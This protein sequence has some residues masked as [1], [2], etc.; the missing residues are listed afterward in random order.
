M[1]ARE[2][3]SGERGARCIIHAGKTADCE[4]TL[5]SGSRPPRSPIFWALLVSMSHL[6]VGG[7]EG[8]RFHHLKCHRLVLSH[9]LW[10]HSALDLVADR[11]G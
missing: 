2:K 10:C 11:D 9:K 3:R 7:S 6:K 5:D 4:D 1:T 8:A